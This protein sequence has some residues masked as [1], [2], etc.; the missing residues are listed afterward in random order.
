MNWELCSKCIISVFQG[1]WTCAWETGVQLVCVL[2][3]KRARA[4][5]QAYLIVSLFV[6]VCVCACF[7]RFRWKTSKEAISDVLSDSVMAA[8][9]QLCPHDFISA[10]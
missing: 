2:Q 3:G 4:F 8:Q 5:M 7:I 6:G 10:C 9:T 1:A